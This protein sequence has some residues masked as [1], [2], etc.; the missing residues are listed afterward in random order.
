MLCP[1]CLTN[2]RVTSTTKL[3]YEGVQRYRYCPNCHFGFITKETLQAITATTSI[4]NDE[5]KMTVKY[6]R[7]A[8][9]DGQAT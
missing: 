1:K 5:K 3:S 4:F 6:G 9:D 2:T 8:T 7:Q